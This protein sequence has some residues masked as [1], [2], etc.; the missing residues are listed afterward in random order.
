MKEKTCTICNHL[1]D[2]RELVEFDDRLFC[3]SCL[4]EQTVICLDCG[5]RIYRSQ[6][7]GSS[8]HPLCE[9]C[10]D[11]NYTY[12]ERCGRMIHNDAAYYPE[13]SDYPYC[14]SCYELECDRR[15]HEYNYKPEPIFHGEGSRFFGVELEIDEGGENESSAEEILFAGNRSGEHIY[16]KH[17]GS[18]DEGFEI[19]THPMTLDYHLNLMPW[20]NVTDKA[21]RLGYT[22]HQAKTC[23][24]HIHVN[25]TTFGKN[26]EEQD[27]AIARVLYFVE[28]NWNELLIFSRRTQEQLDSWARRYGYKDQ[29]REMLEHVKKGF[30]GRYTCVNLTNYST[31]EFRI[32]RGTLKLNSIFAALQLVN[33]ICDVA[34]FMSDEEVRNLSWSRFVDMIHEPEL[35]QYLKERRI[36]INENIEAEEEL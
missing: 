34:V 24:L 18:L 27:T 32:F 8:E 7:E 9:N 28:R 1:F 16:C 11:E 4:A 3:R 30:A 22:S 25:R 13:D 33:H 17:D 6:N 15:I 26:T 10:H 35:I 29:P 5:E 12:C 21:R 36:Y 14:R 23:G 19:V 20:G 2:E 31:I